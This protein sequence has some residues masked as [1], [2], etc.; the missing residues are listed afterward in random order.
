VPAE[1]F[2]HLFFF[3]PTVNALLT[4]LVNKFLQNQELTAQ[5]YFL[6]NVSQNEQDNNL[7]ALFFDLVRYL[8]WQSKL[9]KKIPTISNLLAEL[10]YHLNIILGTNK[11]VME[12]INNCNLFQNGGQR[13]ADRQHGHP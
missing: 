10:E 5:Q 7:H 6:S 13:A 1:T 3:C 2:S 11:K 8:I 12:Q 9:V 4:A